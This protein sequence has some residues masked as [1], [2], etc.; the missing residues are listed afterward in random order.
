M[1][2][3]DHYAEMFSRSKRTKEEEDPYPSYRPWHQPFPFHPQPYPPS[4]EKVPER[5][6]PAATVERYK[7]VAPQPLPV[8]PKK[9]YLERGMGALTYVE[10]PPPPLHAREA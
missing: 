6:Y 3:D 10:P 7:E 2:D 9:K 1:Q 5:K 8:S 4:K